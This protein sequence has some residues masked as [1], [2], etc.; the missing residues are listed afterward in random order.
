MYAV[1]C[2][3][4]RCAVGWQM[5]ELTGSAWDLGRVGPYRFAPAL[6]LTLGALVLATRDRMSE[7][8]AGLAAALEDCLSVPGRRA[9]AA[10]AWA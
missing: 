8:G 10:P 6:L 5:Y 9:P 7:S 1:L 4:A 2:G 3:A